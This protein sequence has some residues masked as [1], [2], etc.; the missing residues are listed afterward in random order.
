[1]TYSLVENSVPANGATF[2]IPNPANTIIEVASSISQSNIGTYRY[3]IKGCLK[4]GNNACF[5]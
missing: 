1:M 5:G 2:T 3:F 4:V